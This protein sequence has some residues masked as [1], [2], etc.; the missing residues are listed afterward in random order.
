MMTQSEVV[1]V[2]FENRKKDAFGFVY[3]RFGENLSQKRNIITDYVVE[4]GFLPRE[5]RYLIQ[6]FKQMSLFNHEQTHIYQPYADS[7]VASYSRCRMLKVLTR[8]LIIL[9]FHFQLFC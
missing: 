4:I 3:I 2:S 5:I 6:K 7:L 9:Y 8:I 1:F